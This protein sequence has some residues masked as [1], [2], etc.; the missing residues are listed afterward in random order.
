M[1]TSLYRLF[2][3]I[4]RKQHGMSLTKPSKY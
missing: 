4:K 2:F 3:F 1:T